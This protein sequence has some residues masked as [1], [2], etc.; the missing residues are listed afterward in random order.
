M[1]LFLHRCLGAGFV[2]LGMSVAS[3]AGS[4]A[5]STQAPLAWSLGIPVP[6]KVRPALHLRDDKSV[7][8]R[9]RLAQ[10]RPVLLTFVFS[11]C[12]STCPV[13]IAVAQNILQHQSPGRQ[14][15]IA[16][17]NLDPVNQDADAFAAWVRSFD[18]RFVPLW[19]PMP[20]LVRAIELM[21]V[22]V[23]GAQDQITHSAVWYW[24]ESTEAVARV[25]P[26]ATSADALAAELQ[27]RLR[28]QH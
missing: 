22:S 12:S 19:A 14:I 13:S 2:A 3:A 1:K 27:L 15:D 21:G 23:N 25:F 6:S 18:K 10:G 28:T 4:H 9:A 16:F 26:Y 7:S 5:G 8:L 11:G 24:M 20:E 17:V